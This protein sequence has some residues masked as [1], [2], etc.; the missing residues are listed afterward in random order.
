[1]TGK[2]DCIKV[3]MLQNQYK[4]DSGESASVDCFPIRKIFKGGYQSAGHWVKA[5]KST[6]DKVFQVVIGSKPVQSWHPTS[7]QVDKAQHSD[8]PSKPT[9][10]KVLDGNFLMQLHCV[11][12][13]SDLCAVNISDQDLHSVKEED[14]KLFDCVVYVNAAANHLLLEPFR[15]FP[16]IRELD[17]SVNGL[18]NLQLTV[19]DFPHLEVL[20]LSYNKLSD[21]D[22]LALG[23]LPQLKILHLTGNDLNSLP[24]D[25]MMSYD[26]LD[27]LEDPLPRF[28]ALEVLMLDDNRLSDPC[29]FSSLAN[30]QRLKY[31]NL[32]QNSFTGIPYL[33]QMESSLLQKSECDLLSR[34]IISLLKQPIQCAEGEIMETTVQEKLLRRRRRRRRRWS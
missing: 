5:Q 31:L 34:S 20:N 14:F 21:M 13:H 8:K 12:S 18:K 1:M 28:T 23:I 2:P 27:R 24:P 22:I 30:L 6:K 32:D 4:L 10:E 33:Q 7:A 25:M 26:P 29:V 11:V 9:K 17:L 16:A 3:M 19:H 15:L